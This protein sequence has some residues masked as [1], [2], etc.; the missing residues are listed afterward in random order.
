MEDVLTSGLS[1]KLMRY[2]RVR[3]LGEITAGQNDACHLTEGKSLSSAASFRSRDEGRGRVRQV[4]ETTHIDDPRIIDE[5]SLDDQ[6]AEW[7]RDR[8]TNRQLRG[9][10]CWVADRQPPDGVAEAVDM[11]DVDAD[12]EERWH[13]RDVRDGKM[14][15]RDVDENGRDDSSRRRINRGSARS[16]GKG[17]TT[18]GAM[19][20]EQSLTSPGSGSRFG[21]AR[22]MRDRSSSKNLD[23][24]KVLEPK[25]C[26]GKT[27]ADDLVAE[28]EDN[29]EC[30]QGCRIGSKD[31]SDLVK[32]AVRAAEAEARAANAPVEAVKAA[33]DAA[34]EVVKCAALEV[35]GCSHDSVCFHFPFPPSSKQFL[36][37][38]IHS[39]LFL[40]S[41]LRSSKLLTTKKLHY[42]LLPKQQLLLLMLLMPLKFQGGYFLLTDVLFGFPLPS[43]SGNT[44]HLLITGT[45]L[46]Q[47]LIQ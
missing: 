40:F 16:R 4:L 29:D 28:R 27:N 32:K 21:Q 1:A 22:S 24:R 35:P 19:E 6:C 34:A 14:R 7:D 47:V 8:S 3:V 31:F 45:P 15:F 18:E 42:R 25:K 39:H 33:G 9:E 30:F 12:S 26:V 36:L 46:A 44:P 23:G 38:E 17:R 2:L 13:V 41:T 10:E 11:H 20:N 43:A 5:K 37:N